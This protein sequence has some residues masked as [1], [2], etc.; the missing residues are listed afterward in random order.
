MKKLC[1]Y[2][3]NIVLM[4]YLI[5]YFPLFIYV[6]SRILN[7]SLFEHSLMLN[8]IMDKNTIAVVIISIIIKVIFNSKRT[9]V[10]NRNKVLGIIIF[11]LELITVF[12][13]NKYFRT[14]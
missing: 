11:I 12:Y 10:N 5:L 14:I 4:L 8:Q 7:E 13:I 1:Y 9:S 3:S 6:K 2:L